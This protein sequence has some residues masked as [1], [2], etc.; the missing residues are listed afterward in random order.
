MGL[1]KKGPD[2]DLK[3]LGTHS[4][5]DRSML[6]FIISLELL[7]L[8]SLLILFLREREHMR[9]RCRDRERGRGR[10]REREREREREN[11]FQAGSAMSAQSLM[12][13]PI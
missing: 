11:E 8:L 9:E 13:G 10:G 1:N 7:F 12:Q 2:S 6:S 4:Y 5:A 3:M